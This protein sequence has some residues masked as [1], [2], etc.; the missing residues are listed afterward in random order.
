MK[1]PAHK[2]GVVGLSCL[3]IVCSLFH[4]PHCLWLTSYEERRLEEEEEEEEEKIK[5]I[6]TLEQNVSVKATENN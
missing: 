6:L 3:G 2:A 4:N 1:A 5:K